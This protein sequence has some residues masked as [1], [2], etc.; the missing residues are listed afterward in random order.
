MKKVLKVFNTILRITVV[1]YFAVAG[2]YYLAR[3]EFAGGDESIFI[4]DLGLIHEL[5]WVNA[6]QNNISVPF[7]LISF[8][9][10]IFLKYHFALRLTNLLLMIG[11]LYYL[12][13]EKLN[14]NLIIYFL[15]LVACTGYLFYGTNDA[16]FCYSLSIFLIETQKA[17]SKKKSSFIF[18][19]SFLII[20]IFT[21]E[22]FLVYLPIIFPALYLQCKRYFKP[23]YLIYPIILLFG[24]ILINKPSLYYNGRLSYDQKS[25][26]E[27]VKAD[28]TQRQYLAQIMVNNG[29]L[30]F[31]SHPS[32]QETDDYLNINGSN[33]LPK[34]I[35]NGIFMN[36]EM[37]LKEFL[38]DLFYVLVYHIRILGLIFLIPLFIAIRKIY[39][40]KNLDLSFYSPISTLTMI[41]I[42]AL[43]IISYVE[44][45][46][47]IPVFILSIYHFNQLEKRN[48]IPIRLVL[49]NTIM[50]VTISIYGSFSLLSIIL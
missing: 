42:F 26:P 47:L 19:L 10:S 43:I 34:G 14:S 38:K 39:I 24:L 4:R 25:P 18:G 33:S 6:I 40:S 17:V 11:F 49:L 46:W 44:M 22:L 41:C 13:R 5:G 8:P 29:D 3:S 50:L 21:R 37:T 30:E 2:F 35:L 20:A 45:R 32:W 12:Y 15:F 7:M 16:L 28:W 31:Q 27:H 36:I 23:N 48:Q 9:F 1:I